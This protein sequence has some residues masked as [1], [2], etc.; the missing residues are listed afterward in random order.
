[1]SPNNLK[2]HFN[3]ILEFWN[4]N[5]YSEEWHEV[6]VVPVPNSGDLSYPNKLGGVNLMD[7][8]SDIFSS[9]MWKIL[10]RI[11]KKHGVKYQFGY[12]PG[13]G[14]QYGTIT[15]KR[16]STE[17]QSLLTYLCRFCGPCQGV[18]YCLSHTDAPD[19]EEV[20]CPPKA[21]LLHS[22]NVSGSK[23]CS[24]NWENWVDNES[25]CRSKTR[26]VYGPGSIPL[27]WLWPS[28][29]HLKRNVQ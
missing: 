21:P 28:P 7:I 15:I 29:K 12:S 2:V 23:S 13:V 16:Y 26:G 3:F 9:L 6:Q 25:D 18:W 11:I 20:W 19:I 10:F 8:G 27:H 17:T 5:L 22:Y 14:C 4:D 24:Q 1:M